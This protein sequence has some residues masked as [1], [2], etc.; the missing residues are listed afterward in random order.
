MRHT[1]HAIRFKK[2][3]NFTGDLVEV[4]S[5]GK[6]GYAMEDG[7]IIIPVKYDVIDILKNRFIKI[8]FNGLSLLHELSE[9][10]LIAVSNGR[11]GFADCVGVEVVTVKYDYVE[12][13]SEGLADVRLNDKYGFI[14]MCNRDV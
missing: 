1:A 6:H 11:Y 5:S 2:S 8:S 4:R 10:F 3:K 7:K 12:P 9:G 13:F 14:Y